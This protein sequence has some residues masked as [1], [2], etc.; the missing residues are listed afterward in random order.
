MVSEMLNTCSQLMQLVDLE[1]LSHYSVL[2]T[3][4]RVQFMMSVFILLA[5]ELM[6]ETDVCTVDSCQMQELHFSVS[7]P[8]STNMTTCGENIV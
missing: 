1:D 8:W 4:L 6:A 2:I 3:G 5:S 7:K